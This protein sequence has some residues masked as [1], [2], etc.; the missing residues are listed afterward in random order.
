MAMR[1][2]LKTIY[3]Y[4]SSHKD[5]NTRWFRLYVSLMNEKENLQNL[6]SQNTAF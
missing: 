4:S 6:M 1:E 2:Q 5:N 3:M